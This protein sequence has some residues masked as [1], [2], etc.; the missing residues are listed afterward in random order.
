MARMRSKKSKILTVFEQVGEVT[1]FHKPNYVGDDMFHYVIIMN[2]IRLRLRMYGKVM[3][4]DDITPLTMALQPTL[5]KSLA[6]TL[7]SQKEFTVLVSILGN[8]GVLHSDC[9]RLT[10]L[11][12][13]DDQFITQP[14]TYYQEMRTY[15]QNDESKY[16]FYL[17][18]AQ[19]ELPSDEEAITDDIP[20]TPEPEPLVEEPEEPIPEP[21]HSEPN[22]SPVK[23]LIDYIETH[24][25]SVK[26]MMDREVNIM[27]YS[28]LYEG[29][30]FTTY[31]MSST[32]LVINGINFTSIGHHSSNGDQS[33][34]I[35]LIK[36]FKKLQEIASNGCS[37]QLIGISNRNVQKICDQFDFNSTVQS[38]MWAKNYIVNPM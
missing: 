9:A 27:T 17:L 8:T 14:K 29:L 22:Y 7:F 13:A 24:K 36:L 15:Y 28:V 18:A 30:R 10:G 16:G 33:S 20:V 2:R 23:D 1:F 35:A 19:E 6:E 38:T 3:V 11:I 21:I 37:I 31:E 5:Y 26:D 4:I 34:E 32:D 12:V 25:C